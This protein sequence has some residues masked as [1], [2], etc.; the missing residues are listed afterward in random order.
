M[1]SKKTGRDQ[2]PKTSQDLCFLMLVGFKC[3]SGSEDFYH[4]DETTDIHH[5][6]ARKALANR[7]D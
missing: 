5:Q 3:P 6:A 4:P 1:A 2:V 7:C